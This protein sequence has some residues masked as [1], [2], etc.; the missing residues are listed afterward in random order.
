MG[1][2]KYKLKKKF[3]KMR[4]EISK[5]RL[6]EA[7]AGATQE[8]QNSDTIKELEKRLQ[9]CKEQIESKETKKQD[10]LK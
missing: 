2:S 6:D 9:C 4:T 1:R 5:G 3:K 8:M 10:E 7:S